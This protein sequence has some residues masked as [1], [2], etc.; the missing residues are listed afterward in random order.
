[1][2]SQQVKVFTDN[3]ACFYL[4]QNGRSAWDHRLRMAR[5]FA[6]SQVDFSY[7]VE[8]AWISTS[9]NWLADALSRPGEKKFR[10]IFDEFSDGLGARPVQRHILP[11]MFDF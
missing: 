5:I 6:M 4:A 11:S 7:R 8:P 3:S 9:D 10:D 2:E 1:M